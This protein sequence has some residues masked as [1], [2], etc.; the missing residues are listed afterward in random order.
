MAGK[1]PIAAI[2][3]NRERRLCPHILGRNREGQLRLLGYQ[4][5]GE[6]GS[7]LQGKDGRGAWRCFAVDKL[8][9]VRL[10]EGAWWTAD[11][12]GGRPTCIDRIEMTAGDQPDREPQNGQ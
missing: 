7:G 8:S 4:Y 9:G 10:L 11:T 5:G 3:E 1:Q 2:Y 6:S 12:G